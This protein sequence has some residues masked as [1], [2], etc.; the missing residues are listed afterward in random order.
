MGYRGG[1]NPPD[2]AD[3]VVLRAGP[4]RGKA[5]AVLAKLVGNIRSTIFVLLRTAP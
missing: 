3:E 5:R 1:G 4:V 2:S